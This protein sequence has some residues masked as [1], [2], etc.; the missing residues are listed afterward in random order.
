[1]NVANIIFITVERIVV[2]NKAKRNIVSTFL[3]RFGH[4][5]EPITKSPVDEKLNLPEIFIRQANTGKLEAK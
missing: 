2:L 1:M 3:S 5:S 4:F